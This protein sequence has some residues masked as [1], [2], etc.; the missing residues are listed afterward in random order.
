MTIPVVAHPIW[1]HESGAA[2]NT[3]NVATTSGPVR[4]EKSRRKSRISAGPRRRRCLG[5]K[6]CMPGSQRCAM[7]VLGCSEIITNVSISSSAHAADVVHLSNRSSTHRPGREWFTVVSGTI[8]P[9]LGERAVRLE[10]GRAAEFSTMLAHA[11]KTH[12]IPAEIL[13]I[14]EHDDR[15]PI[16]TPGVNRPTVRRAPFRAA[17][18][19]R[20][21]AT[22]GTRRPPPRAVQ[23]RQSLDVRGSRR[24]GIE[25]GALIEGERVSID[26]DLP[27]RPGGGRSS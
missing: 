7:C 11:V 3:V 16:A 10:T 15:A 5:E 26:G 6:G 19:G 22:T 12:H 23:Q 24:R 18:L 17:G 4:W 14:L 25:Y 20:P 27:R 13:V 21:G 8:T 9:I 1:P 2:T